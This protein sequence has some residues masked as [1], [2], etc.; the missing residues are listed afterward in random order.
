MR[1]RLTA[2]LLLLLAAPGLGC[3]AER[4]AIRKDHRELATLGQQVDAYWTAVR[5]GDASEAAGALEREEDRLAYQDWL[6]ERTQKERLSDVKIL[7]IE[8]GAETDPP[9]AGVAREATVQV[10]AEGYS[11]PEQIL[12]TENYEQRWYRTDKG[13]F[14]EWP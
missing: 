5:W 4:K 6:S 14:L 7:R 13:W 12:R 10:R 2:T 11:L 1:T 8:L 9:V 3:T